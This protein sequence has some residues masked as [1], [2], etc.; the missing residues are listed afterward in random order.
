[1]SD[2][3]L[4]QWLRNPSG[5]VFPRC[6]AAADRIEAIG[7][8]KR[9]LWSLLMTYEAAL[10]EIGKNSRDEQAVVCVRRALEGEA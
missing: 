4:L 10:L 6:A 3:W 9:E 1:M 5:D 7:A 8:E 2:D